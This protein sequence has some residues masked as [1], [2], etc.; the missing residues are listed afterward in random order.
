MYNRVITHIRLLIKEEQGYEFTMFHTKN[1]F[2]T[3][4][5]RLCMT[6]VYYLSVMV[7][8]SDSLQ[9]RKNVKC[10]HANISI[11]IAF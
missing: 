2:I 6:V 7:Y 11:Y 5:V 4:L 9:E 8:M 1:I 3:K 10:Y